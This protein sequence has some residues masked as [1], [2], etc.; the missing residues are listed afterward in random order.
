LTRSLSAAL[1]PA[2]VA[3]VAALVVAAGLI[4]GC[5][6]APAA[7]QSVRAT[8]QQ[9]GAILSDGPDPTED[10]VGYAE[11]QILPLRGVHTANQALQSAVDELAAAYE[12]Y[13]DSNGARAAQGAVN[14]AGKKLNAICPGTVS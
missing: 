13:F 9:V 10:P 3:A 12:Q 11:A 14:A 6:A 4:S 1:G 2:A 7:S 8:C 5:G